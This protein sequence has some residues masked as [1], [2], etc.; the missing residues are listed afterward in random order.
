M[1]ADTDQAMQGSNTRALTG[2][3]QVSALLGVETRA[4]T[5]R[6]FNLNQPADG[7]LDAC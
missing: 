5:A 1:Q 3:L 4:C 7:S 2:C 6:C